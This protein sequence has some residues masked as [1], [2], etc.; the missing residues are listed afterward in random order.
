VAQR[1]KALDLSARD[2]AAVPGSNP[3]AAPWK[4]VEK[5]ISEL[6][7][8]V[9]QTS[10]GNYGDR[11]IMN[12]GNYGDRVIMNKGNYGDRVIMNKGNYVDRVLINKGNYVDSWDE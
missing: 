6:E 3:S 9:F 4:C 12:K 10:K 1:S 2:I 8:T 5:S 7:H 11:V